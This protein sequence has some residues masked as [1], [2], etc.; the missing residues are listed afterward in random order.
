MSKAT[1]VC[2]LLAACASGGQVDDDG[3]SDAAVGPHQDA[4]N[5]TMPDAKVRIDGGVTQ[6]ADAQVSQVPQDAPA[7]QG[8][9]CTVNSQ[10][11]T[12]GQCCVTLGGPSGFCA[13]GT[14]VLG[15][16]VPQ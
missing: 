12:S 16:C 9:F 10:C 1:I 11:T 6:P 15:Q 3:K 7:N 4:S 13:P 2:I 5:V 8:P 14:V